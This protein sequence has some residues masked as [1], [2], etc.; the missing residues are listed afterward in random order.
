MFGAYTHHMK[1]KRA[2]S[3]PEFPRAILHVDGDAF[4]A[5][6]EVARRPELRGMPVV[7]GAERGIATAFS[8]EAKALGVTR[9]MPISRV[10]RKFPQATIFSGDYAWYAEVSRRMNDILLSHTP[11]VEPYSIDE[12][13]ADLTGHQIP[14]KLTY[15]GLARSIKDELQQALGMTFSLGVAPTK[16]L[17]KTAAKSVK[18]DGCVV[19]PMSRTEELLSETPIETIWGIGRKTAPKLSGEGIATA[20]DL[21][22]KDEAWV[23]THL[24]KPYRD[25]WAELR[26]RSVLPVMRGG[27]SS[28]ESYAHTRTFTPPSSD[29]T[30]LLRELAR[31]IE[32]V[33]ESVREDGKAARTVGFFLKSQRFEYAADSFSLLAPSNIPEEILPHIDARIDGILEEGVAYRATGITLGNITPEE[34]VSPDLFDQDGRRLRLEKVFRGVDRV[35][36]RYGKRVV[37]I[38]AGAKKARV[39]KK[40]RVT[41][42]IPHKRSGAGAERHTKRMPF[43]IRD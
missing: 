26:G 16:V 14:R 37:R 12:C 15:E 21:R 41:A 23:R 42:P 27:R 3:D 38:A 1:K 11:D 9:G 5:S 10:K 19:I 35:N 31:H 40:S 33:C 36:E 24:A 34:A 32:A 20:L 2:V 13:F 17:A 39:S 29:R 28:Q 43:V 4:F 8:Y 22:K 25:I 6:C 30:F 7:V 18:P